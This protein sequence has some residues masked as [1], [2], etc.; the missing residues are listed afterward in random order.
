M[1][2]RQV[3]DR[4]LVAIDRLGDAAVE[5]YERSGGSPLSGLRVL[6]LTRVIAGPVATRFLAGWGADVLR[7]EAPGFHEMELLHIEVGFGKRS[8][9]LDLRTDAGRA[10]FEALVT[11]ADVVVHGYR[12]G[13]LRGLGYPAEALAAL[14]P[15]LVVAGLSAYG[16]AGPW[17]ERRGFD[18]LVQMSSGIAAEGAAVAGSERPVPLPCQLLDHATGYLLALGALRGVQRRSRDGGSWV[19]GV[20]LARTAAWLERLGRDPDGFARPEPTADEVEPWCQIS[21]TPWGDVHHVGPPGRIGDARPGWH[22]PPSRPGTDPPC[23]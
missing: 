17:A 6:D 12:P 4:P 18:S 22:R 15:G 1:Y 19:V 21:P 2:K 8:C 16:A 23:W 5:A 20:S 11:G 7:V 9:E 3:E 14:R 10:A 13:A